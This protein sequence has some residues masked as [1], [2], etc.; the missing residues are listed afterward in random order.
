MSENRDWIHCFWE[1]IQEFIGFLNDLFEEL[2]QNKI[3]TINPFLVKAAGEIVL[4]WDKNYL[5]DSF[6]TKS[7]NE[8][9]KILIG[10]VDYF[11][12]HAFDFFRG[13]SDDTISMF[14]NLFIQKREDNTPIIEMDDMECIIEFFRSFVRCSIQHIHD[15]RVPVTF[16]FR[17]YDGAKIFNYQRDNIYPSVVLENLSDKWEITLKNP[18]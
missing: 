18:T 7:Y 12:K 13:L 16:E 10:D 5:I 9:E 17:A 3:T 6:I 1:N 11:S 14:Q 2:Y 8:W 15:M 4:K